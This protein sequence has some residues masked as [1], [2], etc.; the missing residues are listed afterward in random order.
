MYLTNGTSNYPQHFIRQPI[1]S[2]PEKDSC[3]CLRV[4]GLTH[5][6]SFNLLGGLPPNYQSIGSKVSY[7]Y[8]S[9]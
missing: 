8:L 6:N 3:L 9:R 2:C 7:S 4:H 5:H 1:D